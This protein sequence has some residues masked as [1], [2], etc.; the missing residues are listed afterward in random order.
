MT[1]E[2]PYSIGDKLYVLV[3][4]DAKVSPVCGACEGAKTFRVTH[5]DGISRPLPCGRCGGKGEIKTKGTQTVFDVR[6]F[7]IGGITIKAGRT[8]SYGNEPPTTR[9]VQYHALQTDLHRAVEWEG[10]LDTPT[11]NARSY[12]RIHFWADREVAVAVAERWTREIQERE[13]R[14]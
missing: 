10:T 8:E 9:V 2:T 1:F 11:P 4:R 3:S 13:A 14:S 6:L 7:T 5:A 12:E